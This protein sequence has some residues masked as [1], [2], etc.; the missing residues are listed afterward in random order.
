MLDADQAYSA[1]VE[2][3]DGATGL[4]QIE[5]YEIGGS[6]SI[7]EA[8][9]GNMSNRALVG[10]DHER[11]I[12]SA[13][14]TG[15]SPVEVLVVARGSSLAD[16]LPDYTGDVLTDPK[17]TLVDLATKE[18]TTND[19]FA[20]WNEGEIE[21]R[22][23]GFITNPKESRFHSRT[24]CGKYLFCYCGRSGRHDRNWGRLNSTNLPRRRIPDLEVGSPTVNDD[25]PETGGSFTLSATVNNTGD[26]EAAA[27]T[28]RY[29]RSTDST[30]TS[31]DTEGWD[32]RGGSAGGWG[33]QRPVYRLDRP[34]DGGDILLRC[35]RGCGD[36]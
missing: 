26:G 35:V 20:H 2:G 5:F 23:P 22:F 10:L 24:T 8:R 32:G 36:G 3:V 14:T 11:L 29:Y 13:M 6:G 19:N 33:Y 28:L 31:S 1:I 21:I 18:E 27:T 15:D 4:G 30:I 17:L 9:L 34:V 7:T 12:G 25:S 16:A